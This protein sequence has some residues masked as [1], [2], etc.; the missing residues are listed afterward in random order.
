MKG[1]R[2]W[3]SANPAYAVAAVVVAGLL[4]VG[5]GTYVFAVVTQ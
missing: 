1:L 5:I 2:N 4:L 3:L